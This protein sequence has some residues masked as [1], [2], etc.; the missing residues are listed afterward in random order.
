MR[1]AFKAEM[2]GYYGKHRKLDAQLVGEALSKLGDGNIMSAKPEQIVE[3]ARPRRS[4]LHGAFDWN[5]TEA[6]EKWRIS[7]A[8]HL[9]G[10]I[11]TT[12]DTKDGEV[13]L[14]AFASVKG[15][16]GFEYQRIDRI[17]GDDDLRI[18][19]LRDALDD[20]R[21]FQRR[22]KALA[23]VLGS[24]SEIERRIVGELGRLRGGEAAA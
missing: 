19:T 4:P 3:A 15:K 2:F 12:I 20:L 10:A 17:M 7:Q 5:D 14:R 11:V 1:F 18:Q 6:A 22:Y 23:D 16:S 21:A 13:E 8:R 24:L 9:V